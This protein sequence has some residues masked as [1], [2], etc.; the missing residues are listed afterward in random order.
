[1]KTII[2]ER[3]GTHP[4]DV[5]HYDTA[6]LRKEFLVEKLFESDEVR[7]VYTHNDR[8]IIGG[9]FPANENLTL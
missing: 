1:M 9:A 8:L 7:M 4:E 5:K 2:E 3:W 6:Q